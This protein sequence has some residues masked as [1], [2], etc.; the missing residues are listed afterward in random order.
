MC[1]LTEGLIENVWA[2][3]QAEAQAEAQA[4]ID[5]AKEEA[6]TFA[7]ATGAAVRLLISRGWSLSDIS[8]QLNLPLD[9]VQ[10]L[11]NG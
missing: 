5:A 3:A 6:R 2:K 1:T 8:K 7:A 9:K 4:K 10:R 11:S